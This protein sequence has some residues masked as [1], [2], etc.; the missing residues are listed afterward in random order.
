[1]KYLAL[2]IPGFGQVQT[3]DNIPSGASA[4]GNTIQTFL[5]LFIYI[6]ITAALLF[7]LY[8]GFLWITS[9]GDKAKLDHA[10]RTIT[11]AII[12][13]IIIVFAWVIVGIISF[14]LGS[15]NALKGFEAK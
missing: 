8:G 14:V 5:N 15:P 9:G 2:K 7:T 13:I 12:G 6:G 4:P 10:R 1:M 11:Y 3:P